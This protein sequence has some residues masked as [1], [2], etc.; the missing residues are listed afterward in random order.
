[1]AGLDS[2]GFTIPS[3]TELS[4]E[5]RTAVRS[6]VSASLDLE[7]ASFEGQIVDITA[8]QLR[9]IWEALAALYGA[10]NP[11]GATGVTLSNI[12]ALTGTTRRSATKSTVSA[13]VN[14]DPGT[15]AIGTLVAHV[16]GKPSD[17]FI[18][19][20]IITNSGGSATDVTAS[21]ESETAGAVA[22]PAGALSV[23]AGPVTGWNSILNA[24]AATLGTEVELDSELRLRRTNEVSA[25][26]SGTVQAI[27]ADIS[28]NVPN[29]VQVNTFE[30]DT[31]VT[32]ADGRPP[33]S[34]EVVVFGPAAPSAADDLAVATIINENKPAGIQAFGTTTVAVTNSAG[35]I[36]GVSFSR[37][38]E[39]PISVLATVV[40]FEGDYVASAAESQLATLGTAAFSVG[41]DATW[42][43]IVELLRQI[44]GVLDVNGIS[45][46][47]GGLVSFGSVSISSREIATFSVSN[48]T[49]AETLTSDPIL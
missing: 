39:I 32:D 35:Q 16:S 6:N 33:H 20:D 38:A 41:Q 42:S 4:D 19:S 1:M 14:V 17:R 12:S 49:I 36:V 18:N 37:P 15:Y 7:T 10:M 8:R 28:Q 45:I 24:T 22:A 29:V 26:G 13:V 48:I 31:E 27:S 3:L 47:S 21:F 23:I 11:E 46:G 34:F 30:N 2:N 25:Q 9:L 44:P 43:H 40:A 5:I